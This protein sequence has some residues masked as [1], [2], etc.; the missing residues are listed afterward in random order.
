MLPKLSDLF[1]PSGEHEFVPLTH[2]MLSGLLHKSI[3]SRIDGYTLDLY[4]T[5]SYGNRVIIT[6]NGTLIGCFYLDAPPDEMITNN[7]NLVYVCARLCPYFGTTYLDGC[8]LTGK[9]LKQVNDQYVL[10][11][12]P[13][14]KYIE[15]WWAVSPIYLH[16]M[17][18]QYCLNE[19]N[20]AIAKMLIS[21]RPG[22]WRFVPKDVILLIVGMISYD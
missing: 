10:H 5:A 13:L 3:I 9:T 16:R 6:N 11:S 21:E 7:G 18:T 19:V 15:A 2:G 1:T 14:R 17:E 8:D 22:M 20:K 4:F 12:E